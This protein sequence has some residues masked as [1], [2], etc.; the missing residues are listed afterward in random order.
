M[1]TDRTIQYASSR[2]MTGK[3]VFTSL[4]GALWDLHF[5]DNNVT[6][7][8]SPSHTTTEEVDGQEQ[9]GVRSSVTITMETTLADE[10][11]DRDTLAQSVV[12]LGFEET[13][14][15]ALDAIILK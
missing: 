7:D 2:F 5:A 11:T 3:S 9:E 12:D 6:V 8:S 13:T 4:A 1:P 15:D 14:Q 10:A